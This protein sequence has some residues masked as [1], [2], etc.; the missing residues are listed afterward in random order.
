MICDMGGILATKPGAI[1]TKDDLIKQILKLELE[2]NKFALPEELK[3]T[4]EN[5]S[6][7]KRRV[8]LYQKL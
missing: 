5:I 1:V 4:V 6:N 2:D 8:L 3:T 7:E